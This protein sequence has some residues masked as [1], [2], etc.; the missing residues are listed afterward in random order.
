[1]AIQDRREMILARCEAIIAL[2]PGVT[3]GGRNRGDVTGKRRPA[4]ILLDGT[5]DV[6]DEDASFRGGAKNSQIQRMRMEPQF[7][8]KCSGP[9]D[10]V[11]TIANGLRMALLAALFTDGELLDLVGVDRS[12]STRIAYLGGGLT[13]E[14]GEQREA[15]FEV[16]MALT[17]VFRLVDLV[18]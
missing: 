1:M 3:I 10:E 13:T 6:A 16:N 8:I 15:T 2:V 17:Y 7:Q 11:G 12:N 9:A 5:E 4:I 18:A 14:E